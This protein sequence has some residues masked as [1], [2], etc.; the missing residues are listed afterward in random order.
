MLN[1]FKKHIEDKQ[2][3]ES[4]HTLLLAIS[5][6]PD[7]VALACLLKECGFDFSLAHCNF[8]LRGKESDADEAFCKKLAKKLDV[9]LHIRQF[10]T[11][12]LVKKNGDSI[13][14][15]A[16]ALRYAWFD[17]LLRAKKISFLL[18]AHNANDSIETLFI[19]LLR[20]TGI[21]GIKGIP[22]Q[23][24]Q[25]I[26]PLLPFTKEEILRYLDQKKIAY[27]LDKSNL[28]TVY[29]RNFLRLKIIP[30]LKELSPA[31]EQVMLSNMSHFREEADL[32]TKT[33]TE[34]LRAI[35]EQ[36]GGFIFIDKA[37]LKNETGLRSLLHT[38]LSPFGFNSSQA[39]SIAEHIRREGLV[40]KM[41][42]SLS[43]CLTID[44]KRLVIRENILPA[45]ENKSIPSLQKLSAFPGFRMEKISRFAVPGA[46]ELILNP[47]ALIFPLMIR[48][49]NKGDKFIPFGMKGFK[50]LSDFL[51]DQKLNSF[52]KENCKLLVNGNNEI[53][54]VIGYRSDE[55]YR[56]SQKDTQLIKLTTRE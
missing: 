27:R 35:T 2:L 38:A 44:R 31:F 54:W 18:T 56:V 17:E 40:G 1:R 45:F 9:D 26:R 34:K 6:G 25:L 11:K 55:R 33:L 49:K 3:F 50:L 19:N 22:E 39:G 16:R 48:S 13:Q 29:E 23:A 46:G 10:D 21:N 53:I 47:S 5:G 12:K 37:G 30:L 4:R 52:E 8:K 7:S 43:H 51:K 28:E 32:V 41:I 15:V 20:G 14:M 36:K 24:G 42:Y